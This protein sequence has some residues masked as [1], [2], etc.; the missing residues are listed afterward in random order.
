MSTLT[1]KASGNS[2]PWPGRKG[3]IIDENPVVVENNILIRQCIAAGELV[4]VNSDKPKV[5]ASKVKR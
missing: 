2:I 3:L 4:I 1:V 5:Q